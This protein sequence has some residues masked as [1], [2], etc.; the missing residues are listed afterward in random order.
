VLET[1]EF[2]NDDFVELRI[3]G[4][5]GEE[6]KITSTAGHPF[7]VLRGEDLASRPRPEH[8]QAA[9]QE[10]RDRNSVLAGRWVDAGDLLPGD[11]LFLRNERQVRVDAVE[12]FQER[13][14]TYNFAVDDLHCYAVGG[15]AVLVHNGCGDSAELRK[16][17]GLKKGDGLEAHHIVPSS[18][19]QGQAAREL[20]A[21]H[22]IPINSAVNGVPLLPGAHRGVGLHSFASINAV[23]RRLQ[24][25]VRGL[26]PGSAEAVAQLR[27]T[28]AA[29]GSEIASGSVPGVL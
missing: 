12:L 20:L 3:D 2:V 23:T 15:L 9:E 25:A 21:D 22:G 1:Y 4:P 10:L 24:D 18:H 17:L 19:R 13:Q 8:I 5:D 26:A 27:Q 16:N 29:I 28:L 6:D 11:V 14:L 7:W